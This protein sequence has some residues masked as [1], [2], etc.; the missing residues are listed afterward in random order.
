[1]SRRRTEAGFSLPGLLAGITI[2]LVL[3]TVAVPSWQYV[4]KDAREEELIFRGCQIADAIER[5]QKK[6]GNAAPISLEILVQGRYLRKV[7]TEPMSPK[8]KW[9]FIRMGEPLGPVPGIRPGVPS[10]SPSPSRG[11]F[12][13]GPGTALGGILGVAST[14]QERSLRMFNGRTKYSDWLFVAGQP[15]VVGRP[16]GP[17]IA[18]GLGPPRPSP[19][20]GAMN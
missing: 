10:P 2:M 19:R 16:Q 8:G 6:N 12:G 13:V 5:F 7:Y 4:M 3:M 11:G 14:S 1:M 17:G 18:P 9:R 15:R 20:P